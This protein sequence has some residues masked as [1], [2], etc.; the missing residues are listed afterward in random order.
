MVKPQNV[1]MSLKDKLVN[2]FVDFSAGLV[3]TGKPF[4]VDHED[5]YEVVDVSAEV[6]VAYIASQPVTLS[7]GTVATPTAFVN[8][9]SLGSAAVGVGNKIDVTQT[10]TKKLPKGTPLV[11]TC[12][13]AASQTGEGL[14]QVRLRPMERANANP[15]KRPGGSAQDPV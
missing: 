14:V 3:N 1:V 15:T 6:S 2:L 5:D 7:V 13:A 10:S 9:Q 8:A 12:A 4:F 11:V